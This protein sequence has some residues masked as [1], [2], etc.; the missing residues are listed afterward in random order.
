M[1]FILDADLPRPTRYIRDDAETG[2]LIV[3]VFIGEYRRQKLQFRNCSGAKFTVLR[4]DILIG[5]FP[6]ASSK[7]D[8]LRLPVPSVSGSRDE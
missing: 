8:R 2:I 1:E 5:I 3:P 4:G 7:L 6:N